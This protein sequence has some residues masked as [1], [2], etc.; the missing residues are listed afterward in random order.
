MN[1]LAI[2]LFAPL[3]SAGVLIPSL[4]NFFIN[5]SFGLSFDMDKEYA[6]HLLE[7]TRQDYNTIGELFSKTRSYVWRELEVLGQYT[8]AGERVLDLGCGNGRMWE[9]LKEKNVDYIGIDSS[10]RLIEIAK[11]RYPKNRFQKANALNLPFP[12]NYFDKIYSIA[13]FHHIPSKEFRL[14]FLR[15]AKRV[16]KPEGLLILTVWNLW[17]WYNWKL[18]LKFTLLKIFGK[19]RLDFKDVFVPWGKTCQRYVH[20]FSQRELR[21]LV[22]ETEFKIKEIGFL[23]RGRIEKANIYLIAK[24]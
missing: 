18:L 15:E 24:K 7:K 12:P 3:K 6:K 8:F 22:K 19:S 10:E 14:Q 23:S 17:Q 13:V 16:L 11:K 4:I 1:L 5:I 9:V 2:F 20:N 21:K